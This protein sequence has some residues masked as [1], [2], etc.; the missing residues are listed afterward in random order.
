ME[1]S[2]KQG[3]SP[4]TFDFDYFYNIYI[5]EIGRDTRQIEFCKEHDLIYHPVLSGLYFFSSLFEI[6]QVL[7]IALS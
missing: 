3:A 7:L 2:D 1:C 4:V 5:M 6:K